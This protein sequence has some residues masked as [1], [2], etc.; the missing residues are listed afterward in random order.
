MLFIFH[1]NSLTLFRIFLL[2]VF[3]QFFTTAHYYY[4]I[5]IMFILAITDF[6]DGV[7]ARR[8]SLQTEFGAWLDPFADKL[9]SIAI[10]LA[11]LRTKDLPM[12]LVATVL[13]RDLVLMTGIA[14]F[15]LRR[16]NLRMQPTFSSK[17]LTSLMMLLWGL[18]LLRKCKILYL[19]FL[20]PLLQLI[21]LVLVFWTSYQYYLVAYSIQTQLNLRKHVKSCNK[22]LNTLH[23]QPMVVQRKRTTMIRSIAAPNSVKVYHVTAGKIIPQFARETRSN[24]YR[25]D[26]GYRRRVDLLQDFNFPTASSCI[27]LTKDGK[28]L[29][30]AGTYPP[31]IRTWELDQLSLKFQRNLDHEVLTF[32][33]LDHDWKKLAILREDR[34]VEFHSQGGYHFRTRV[35]RPGRD[36]TYHQHSC[37]LLVVGSSSDL[38]RLNLE[39]GRFMS[40]ITTTSNALNV[41]K[42]F[43]AHQL[44]LTGSEDGFVHGF[45]PRD[46]SKLNS[47]CVE[48]NE[49]ISSMACHSDGIHLSVGTSTG[50]VYLYDLRSRNYIF[51]K[52]MRYDCAIHSVGFYKDYTIAADINVVRLYDK[53]GV[54]YTAWEPPVATSSLTFHEDNGLFLFSAEQE[55][56]MAFFV[57]SL[58]PAPSWCSFL[59]NITEEM[60][61]NSEEVFYDDYK[62]VTKEELSELGMD[63]LVGTSSVK[64]YLHGFYV[65]MKLY[66]KAQ[67]IMGSASTNVDKEVE[68]QEKKQLSVGKKVVAGFDDR[69]AD[70]F[71]DE[72][73]KIDENSEEFIRKRSKKSRNTEN[74][75]FSG[76]KSKQHNGP[77]QPSN[78][79]PNSDN[80]SVYS[81]IQSAALSKT[82]ESE[83]NLPLKDRLK[84]N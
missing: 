80:K 76:H 54:Q 73:F 23:Q 18:I 41:V 68:K 32:E 37:D 75:K 48:P 26:E 20:E 24:V 5:L 31:Q 64:S 46:H 7:I 62:F 3:Y 72:D 79:P 47:L 65:D 42:V 51:K 43:P 74:S 6:F 1:P 38:Y 4:S 45:D 17:T 25:K 67:A 69:F 71:N 36:I 83:R 78:K 16:V 13:T 60:E 58:G 9:C 30:A 57:P 12:V 27:K 8:F 2:P 15:K 53:T 39:E 84:K 63:R 81:V 22:V 19:Q 70:A 44:I 10:G 28:H 34:F 66:R 61:E 82:S 55:R 40:P 21:C 59:D 35:P 29:L 11:Y 56:C 33:T 50:N 77:K 52:D 49:E 14:Y